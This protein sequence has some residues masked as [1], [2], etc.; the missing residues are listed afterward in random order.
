MFYNYSCQLLHLRRFLRECESQVK[1]RIAMRCGVGNQKAVS[2]FQAVGAEP[3]ARQHL[4]LY[5]TVMLTAQ[6][7]KSINFISLDVKIISRNFKIV[8]KFVA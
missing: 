3:K 1:W 8:A 2:I 7:G 4:S 5:N 6:E